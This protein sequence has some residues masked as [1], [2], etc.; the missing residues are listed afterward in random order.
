M[1]VFTL[2]QFFTL[3]LFLFFLFG[4][5][6]VLKNKINALFLFLKKK[7]QKK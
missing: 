4:D 3:F 1:R 2:L 6:R 7:K 5:L